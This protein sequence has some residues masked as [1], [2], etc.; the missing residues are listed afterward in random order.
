MYK[1]SFFE[2]AWD[3]F[4][5]RHRKAPQTW[6]LRMEQGYLSQPGDICNRPFL[7]RGA[8]GNKKRSW[9]APFFNRIQVVLVLGWRRR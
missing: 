3:V 1:P 6:V 7:E 5:V 9:E 8:E 4:S 2:G